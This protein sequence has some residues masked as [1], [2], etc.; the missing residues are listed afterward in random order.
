MILGAS[1]VGEG[2][3][4]GA[5]VPVGEAVGAG[6]QA[7]R[8]IRKDKIKEGANRD[9]RMNTSGGESG[10]SAEFWLNIALTP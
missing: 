5:G 6:A 1:P 10:S 4:K 3:G 9:F 2:P 7:F 8:L